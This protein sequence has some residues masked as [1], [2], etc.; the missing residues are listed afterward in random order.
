MM[1]S[2][3]E[4]DITRPLCVLFSCSLLTGSAGHYV[5][6]Q[7]IAAN[8]HPSVQTITQPAEVGA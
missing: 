6:K 3:I 1:T 7:Q 5:N 8:G 4:S 2:T